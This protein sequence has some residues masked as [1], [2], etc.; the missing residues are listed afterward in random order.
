LAE[1]LLVN[2]VGNASKLKNELD[3]A[4]GHLSGF[5]TKIGKI[6]KTAT[7]AGGIMVGAFALTIKTTAKFEQSMANTASV[8]GAT[9]KELQALS[10]YARKM[11]AQS[12]YSAS[13]AAD[14]MYYL[15]SAGMDT[16][17][18]IGA[19]E[20]TLNLAAATGADLA[21]TSGTVAAALSQ[22]GLQAEES[23]RVANVFAA[24]I[25]G[26]QA[27]IEKLQ[28][29]MSYVGPMAK[30]MGMEI[31]DVCGIL[32]N[33]YNAGYDA[34]T[35]GT[36]LR[37]AFTKLIDVSKEGQVTLDKLG[38]SVTDSAGNMRPFADIIDELGEK[39]MST[40]DAIK[41]FGQRAGPAMLAL[42]SQG[43]GAITEMTEKV[44]GTN[45]AYEMADIQINT[46][47]GS[48]KLLRSAFEEL[49]IT[50]GTAI[51]PTITDLTKSLTA[52]L[53]K[54]S[55]W[56]K[57]NPEL[58][59]KIVKWAAGLS[60]ALMVLGPIAMILPSLITGVTLL[61]GAF[62]PFAAGAAIVIGF[63]K[64][65]EY[66]KETRE[67]AFKLRMG[68][69]EM[70]LEEIDREIDAL[71]V[72]ANELQLAM[73]EIDWG[74]EDAYVATIQHKSYAAE[75]VEVN[76]KLGILYETR[77][78]LTKAE[79]EGIDVT[80]E[81]LKIDKEIAKGQETI[82]K[83]LEDWEE[84]L[85]IYTKYTDEATESEI[86]LLDGMYRFT[87]VA[88]QWKQ[89][90]L[91]FMGVRDSLKAVE[92]AMDEVTVSEET[93]A[94]ATGGIYNKWYE[95][96]K[97][98]EVSPD[99]QA[100]FNRSSEA[101][102]K[103]EGK[104]EET[105][106]TIGDLISDLK[107]AMESGLSSAFYSVLSGAKTFGEAMKDLWK[108]IVDAILQQIARLAA[109]WIVNLIFP[110]GGLGL[111]ILGFN[112]GGGVGYQFGGLVD[113]VPARLTV[114]EYVIDKPMT[115]FIRR[116][117][118]IPQN[119]IE[120]IAGGLPTPAPVAF[121]AGG[122]V[123]TS[124]ITSTS[125]GETKINID[126]HDNRISDNVDIKRLAV[127]ISEEVLRKIELKRRY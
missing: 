21:F 101:L 65:A 4:G 76:E 33:L 19:L 57:K 86:K 30:S 66:I 18:V 115:D 80:E 84:K 126:I 78:E 114:G 94:K 123:G 111:G 67:E 79:K 2:I 55:E 109:S 116:F 69:A 22:F 52:T 121:A 41:I 37:M 102:E 10:D 91:Y 107:D 88:S 125:F 17:Q 119:L 58:T 35:A 124:N 40:A 8:A 117:K 29:S 92:K 44:T 42:V 122:P 14:A 62:L 95:L 64:L 12:V 72:R 59:D 108:S 93:M 32:G 3:K 74:T 87:Q 48:M 73:S 38:V 15:A 99:L 6:G 106:S 50:L 47:Q 60:A 71:A 90:S 39:G 16:K 27:T 23:S 36:S 63:K 45:K 103:L 20:G 61:S 25:S 112:K 5:A 120:A 68:L 53:A 127:T 43:S 56:T 85:K 100:Y 31:E 105:T 11:G 98:W 110:G 97:L 46:F 118:A 104:V 26:S 113:T 34:S 7:I 49:Q 96:A 51:I 70:E 13:E 1:E 75:L 54:I 24:T 77:E 81:K 89:V 82:N 9:G 28:T 83:L